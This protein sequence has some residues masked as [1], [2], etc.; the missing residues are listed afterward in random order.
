MSFGWQT[1]PVENHDI[2]DTWN[3]ITNSSHQLNTH[4]KIPSAPGLTAQASRD[5]LALSPTR[6]GPR[7]GGPEGK[8]GGKAWDITD[9]KGT[10]GSLLHWV[11][12]V[13]S[14]DVAG[15]GR[16]PPL[17]PSFPVYQWALREYG[18]AW[19]HT[20]ASLCDG[21]LPGQKLGPSVCLFHPHI[22][23]PQAPAPARALP[24]AKRTSGHR[25]WPARWCLAA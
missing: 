4:L 5:S 11:L 24:C 14:P 15:H 12:L 22:P 10:T 18:Q 20:L 21:E 19:A 1:A 25:T 17:G 3:H 9:G 2:E 13:L 16:Y 23:L 8:E 6:H 7:L